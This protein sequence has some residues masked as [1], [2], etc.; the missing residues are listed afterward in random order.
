MLHV[1]P[2]PPRAPADRRGGHRRNRCATLPFR[3]N[4]LLL[5]AG[6]SKPSQTWAA[7]VRGYF[8]RGA[9]QRVLEFVPQIHGCTGFWLARSKRGDQYPTRLCHSA[10][11]HSHLPDRRRHWQRG[12]LHVAPQSQR[13]AA[14][15][16]HHAS[17]PVRRLCRRWR[18]HWRG[19][20]GRVGGGGKLA[21][22]NC[23]K[24]TLSALCS[25]MVQRRL[26]R[27]LQERIRKVCAVGGGGR[28]WPWEWN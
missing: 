10:G 25:F 1:A 21:K 17:E 9:T 6:A 13:G 5:S 7:R 3:S 28:K 12:R 24:S 4:T 20:G 11:F 2:V 8:L 22:A 14:A 15:P 27:D 16:S 19:F 23:S 18:E 26:P